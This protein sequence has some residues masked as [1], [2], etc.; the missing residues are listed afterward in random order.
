MLT[1]VVVGRSQGQNAHT[2]GT[3][4]RWPIVPYPEDRTSDHE[5][6]WLDQR[7]VLTRLLRDL[8]GASS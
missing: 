6:G 4:D 5:W 3:T 7:Q 8:G 2:P 1:D